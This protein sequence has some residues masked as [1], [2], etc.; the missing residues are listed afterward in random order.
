MGERKRLLE[1]EKE[2][3]K[4]GDTVREAAIR[5]GDTERESVTEEKE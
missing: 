2:R 1:T 3:N 5:R 4:A